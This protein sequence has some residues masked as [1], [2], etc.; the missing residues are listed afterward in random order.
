MGKKA[1]GGGGS[2]WSDKQR[3]GERGP[4]H[5]DTL[6]PRSPPSQRPQGSIGASGSPLATEESGPA[7]PSLHQDSSEAPQRKTCLLEE[8]TE[9][10]SGREGKS[11]TW[12]CVPS[13]GCAMAEAPW[14]W[15]AQLGPPGRA[16][17]SSAEG[18]GSG[19]QRVEEGRVSR[20]PPPTRTPSTERAR[21]SLRT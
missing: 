5:R 17:E 13:P 19:Q 3:H 15:G 2:S 9:W 20:A 21:A 1:G 14:A 11:A 7:R 10:G 6:T 4:A 16:R 12:A 8:A 18:L